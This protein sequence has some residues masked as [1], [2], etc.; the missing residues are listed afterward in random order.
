MSELTD[1]NPASRESCSWFEDIC[2]GGMII[3]LVMHVRHVTN[4]NPPGWSESLT[5]VRRDLEH[6]LL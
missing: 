5:L 2:E 4:D 3:M 1:K 6:R